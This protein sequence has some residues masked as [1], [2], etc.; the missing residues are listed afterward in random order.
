MHNNNAF[1]TH[2]DD[3]FSI[4]NA[5]LLK[6]LELF[7][8]QRR[9]DF[10]AEKEDRRGF[11]LFSLRRETDYK[12]WQAVGVVVVTD[13]RVLASV[14]ELLDRMVYDSNRQPRLM[15]VKTPQEKKVVSAIK[16]KIVSIAATDGLLYAVT[17][18]GRLLSRCPATGVFED[19]TPHYKS[20]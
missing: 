9:Y 18:D 7:L 15:V 5:T 12:Q 17:A 10:Y 3:F 20:C 1:Q 6:M 13:Q 11:P 2:D 4:G 14:R 19:I 8:G 16:E